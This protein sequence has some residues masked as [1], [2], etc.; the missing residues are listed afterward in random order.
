MVFQKQ[1]CADIPGGISQ[2]FGSQVFRSLDLVKLKH[3]EMDVSVEMYLPKGAPT[4]VRVKVSIISGFKFCTS[5][6]RYDSFDRVRGRHS[7]S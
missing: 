3:E 4:G 2:V 5:Y 1:S 7:P 6:L